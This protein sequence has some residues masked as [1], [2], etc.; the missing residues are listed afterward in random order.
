M[1]RRTLLK[2]AAWTG[3]GLL[4]ALTP[5]GRSA[6]AAASP[7]RAADANPRRLVVVFLRG[8]VDGLNVVVPFADPGYY[9][10][11]S[12]IALA[13]PGEPSGVIDLDG[14]FGLHPALAPLLPMWKS[15]SLGFIHACGSNDPT[16]SHFDAQD[17]MESATPGRK[18]TP[19]GWM[20]RL[21]GTLADDTPTR[22]VSIGLVLPR[23]YTGPNRV[24]S[25]AGGAAAERALA[26]DRPNIATAF[27]QLYDGSD[28]L[29]MAYQDSLKARRDVRR[30][31][32]RPDPPGL[33]AEMV[34]ASNG[35]PLP[36]GFPS[37]AARLARLMRND[38][39]VQLAFTAL[40]GWDTH[41]GQGA[42]EGQLANRLQ[43]LGA[44]LA[45]LASGLGP[46]FDQTMIVVLSE[47]GRTVAQNGNGGTD[48]G[49]GNVMWL[50]GGS[51]AGGKV[52]GQWPGLAPDSLHEGR[53]LAVTTD[54]R[55]IL[56]AVCRQHLGT[57]AAD[58]AAIFPD[59]SASRSI[60][61]LR[62]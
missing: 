6:W 34:A 3:A 30:A 48:H 44:G 50:M 56:S 49:H 62:G 32:D 43:P 40:G 16:R 54:F 18:S 42:A 21:L 58:V 61:L 7:I 47:F 9:R 29:S 33:S 22:A 11:R 5:I 31:L 25:I 45:A 36:N 52:L 28:K 41:A 38:A 57:S 10:A 19:D 4:P 14:R 35:A 39:R 12:T 20:N 17:Y 15:G 46:V 24:A 53:D 37:D 13:P 55:D 26:V 59:Y 23:I 51:L 1:L 8:A 27:G 60:E 2:S